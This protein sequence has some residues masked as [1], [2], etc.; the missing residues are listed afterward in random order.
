MPKVMDS[1]LTLEVNIRMVLP[2]PTLST[3]NYT[4]KT[5]IKPLYIPLQKMEQHFYAT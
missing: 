1:G 4:S 2:N 5:V 3:Y